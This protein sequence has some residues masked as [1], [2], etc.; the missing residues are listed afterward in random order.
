MLAQQGHL[1]ELV[2]QH[3]LI[4]KRIPAHIAQAAKLTHNAKKKR[5]TKKRK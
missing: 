4:K 1:A 2:Q 5:K 3:S